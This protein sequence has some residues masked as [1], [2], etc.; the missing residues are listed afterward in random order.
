M[1]RR[2]PEA[3]R[4]GEGWILLACALGFVLATVVAVGEFY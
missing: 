1:G 2:T 3:M 4:H